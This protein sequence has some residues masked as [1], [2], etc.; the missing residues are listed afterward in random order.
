ML[1]VSGKVWASCG[2]DALGMSEIQGHG[3]SSP[4]VGQTVT[5]EGIITLDS[6]APGGWGG[7]YLQQAD[8]ETDADPRTSEALFIYTRRA[9]GSVGMRVRVTGRVKEYHDLTEL[10]RVSA[11]TLCGS[12][13]LPAPIPVQ[14]PWPDQQPPEHLE[15]MRVALSR[16][17]TLIGH[18]SFARFG[19]L[20]LADQQQVVPTELLAPGQAAQ[21]L[22]HKQA[23][24]RLRLDDNRSTRNPDPLP[25][26]ATRLAGGVPVRAGDLISGLSGILDYRFGHWR[27]QPASEPDLYRHGPRPQA[28]VRSATT[29]L[30]VATLNLGNFFNGEGRDGHFRTSR[31]ARNRQEFAIQVSRVVA[32]LSAMDADVIAAAELENDGYGS[33]SAIAELAKALG[34]HWRFVATPGGAG[35]D[36]IRT[37]LLY[38]EDRVRT[39]GS[40]LRL[41]G[42]TFGQGSRPPVA[43]LFQ[44]LGDQ[45]RRIVRIVVPHL[46]SKACGGAT[47]ADKDQRDGQGCFARHR[48]E[49]ADELAGWLDSL[50]E[51]GNFAGTLVTG[52]L[53]SYAREWPLQRLEQAGLTN[54][55]RTRHDCKPGDCPQTTFRYQGRK[56][57]LDYSLGSAQ[58]LGYVVDA[59]AWQ[60]NA[61]EFPAIGYR[62][63]LSAPADEPWRSSDHD[64]VYTDLAL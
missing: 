58:L 41:T 35:T 38:R 29:T 26:P 12:G 15:N 34:P 61:A 46:K 57:S 31:G 60:I 18:Y 10:T 19:E 6:R 48:S 33:D 9:A 1:A 54:L 23:L 64:P 32:A 51:P 50:S 62:G 14:L 4:L 63:P 56:G 53:N 36:A 21:N 28:P 55:I 20:V 3:H 44:P 11:I 49:A 45:H 47:G 8:G 43:Q 2:D 13:Q 5:V 7:F 37:D 52:D 17:L 59:G 25:W 40:P 27:L 30:R 22:A 39:V 24:N 16:P 42:G